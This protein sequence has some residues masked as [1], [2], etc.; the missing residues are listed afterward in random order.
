[1]VEG[2]GVCRGEGAG[3]ISSTA[4]IARLSIAI[5]AIACPGGAADERARPPLPLVASGC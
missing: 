5:A 3:L 2:S 1:V 4:I